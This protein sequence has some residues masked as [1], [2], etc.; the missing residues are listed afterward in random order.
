M[1]SF[2][3]L[4]ELP[5]R[6]FDVEIRA[7]HRDWK[8]FCIET[9]RAYSPYCPLLCGPHKRGWFSRWRCECGTR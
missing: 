2:T 4:V 8:R 3:V 1:F 7:L 6:A 9:R 5:V